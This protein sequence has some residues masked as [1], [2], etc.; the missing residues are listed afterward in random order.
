MDSKTEFECHPKL[1]ADSRIHLE[2]IWTRH[3]YSYR[4]KSIEICIERLF[5]QSM[6]HPHS[7]TIVIVF[8][9]AV[10]VCN[11]FWQ[12]LCVTGFGAEVLNSA[13]EQQ[14][15]RKASVSLANC[16][17]QRGWETQR[18][19]HSHGAP[20]VEKSPIGWFYWC[21]LWV[22]RSSTIEKIP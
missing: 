11:L 15:D 14:G 10:K 1:Y 21:L 6:N 2:H 19:V 3:I 5:N 13:G 7:N 9:D 4:F 22:V 12:E 16:R 8:S 20:S 17:L 18:Q